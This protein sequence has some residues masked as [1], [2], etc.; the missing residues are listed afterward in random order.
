M[1]CLCFCRMCTRAPAYLAYMHAQRAVHARA[2]QADE[3]AQGRRS[4]AQRQRRRW[5]TCRRPLYCKTCN[6]RA[7]AARPRRPRPRL[8]LVPSATRGAAHDRLLVRSSPGRVALPAI[9]AIAV[10]WPPQ[11][12]LKRPCMRLALCLAHRRLAVKHRHG[13]AELPG[14]KGDTLS[15]VTGP[16]RARHKHLRPRRAEAHPRR[17]LVR[18]PLALPPFPAR[19]C[20]FGRP[21]PTIAVPVDRARQRHRCAALFATY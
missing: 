4:P 9:G 2:A 18:P 21:I 7:K 14:A 1:H 3:A 19:F 12:L 16:S 17:G 10:G 8:P 11:Q 13:A 20:F 6:I 15:A 5:Q